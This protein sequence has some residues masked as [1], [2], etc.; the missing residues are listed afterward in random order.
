MVAIDDTFITRGS[1][2]QT[3]VNAYDCTFEDGHTCGFVAEY[4][5]TVF[6]WSILEGKNTSFNIT[7]HTLKTTSGHFFAMD[8]SDRLSQSI[9]T[10]SIPNKILSQKFNATTGSC[11]SFAYL[12][13]GLQ[14]NEELRFSILLE[15]GIQYKY[16][17]AK[18]SQGNVWHRHRKTITSSLKWQISFEGTAN[19]TKVG[20]IAID[21]V[22]V[23]FGNPCPPTGVCDFEVY[24]F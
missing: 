22:F 7:D 20:I 16:W 18:G 11:L 6:D 3:Y 24:L 12:M 17:F 15:N 10:V 1:C 8:F 19:L 14:N 23:D 21:D 2:V 4:S 5:G 9:Y 13:T